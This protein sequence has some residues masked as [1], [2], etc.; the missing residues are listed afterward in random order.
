[1]NLLTGASLLALAKSIYYGSR[2]RKCKARVIII[3]FCQVQQCVPCGLYI[4][5]T[6]KGE[7]GRAKEKG[8]ER[9]QGDH[10]FLHFSRSDSE[11]ENSDWSELIKCQSSTWYLF[12]IGWK[13]HHA[14]WVTKHMLLVKRDEISLREFIV[15]KASI[16]AWKENRKKQL[17]NRMKEKACQQMRF[18]D[19]FWDVSSPNGLSVLLARGKKGKSCCLCA[20]YLL[21]DPRYQR[22]K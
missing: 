22:Q 19:W 7:F 8:K 3:C 9:L 14:I 13:Q 11:R 1:M 17:K 2:W 10:C 6:R 20:C 4:K 12:Q 21:T 15:E 18:T 5:G 16:S